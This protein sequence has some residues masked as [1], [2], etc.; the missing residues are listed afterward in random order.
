[1][2]MVACE[3]GDNQVFIKKPIDYVKGLYGDI[4]T[5]YEEQE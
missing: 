1:V 3:N 4:K 5:F 2:I